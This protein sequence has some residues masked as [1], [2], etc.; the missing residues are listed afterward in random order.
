MDGQISLDNW[1]E[2][3]NRNPLENPTCIVKDGKSIDVTWRELFDSDK[4]DSLS[5]VTYVSS[6]AFLE[7]AVG[8]FKKVEIILGIEK[9]DFR[10]AFADSLK[11][12]I[13]SEGE[14]FFDSMPDESK[15]RLVNG[16]LQ[17]KYSNP[18]CIIHS[19]FYL[20]SNS[21]TSDTRLIVGS[22]NLTNTAFDNS[23]KQYEDV[24]VY[25]NDALF[26]VY[27]ERFNH[28]LKHT[29]DY[30]P[31]EVREKYKEGK[32]I[33]VVNMTS[34]ELTENLID[35]LKKNDVVLACNEEI[36][37]SLQEV[38]IDDAK[39]NEKYKS[40]LEIINTVSKKP[41]GDKSGK[42][43]MKTDSE[44]EK[45]K[46]NITDIL[47]RRT[48]SE[49]GMERYALTFN[50]AD[51]RQYRIFQ[52]N[53][54]DSKRDPEVYDREASKEEIKAGIENML[55]FLDAYRKF[56]IDQTEDDGR[57]SRLFEIILYAF[58]SAYIFRIRQS[59]S[60][61][62]EDVPVIL[63]I[64]GKSFSGKSNLL[65]Y[66]DRILSG[67]QLENSKHYI[68]YKDV[69]KGRILEDLFTT[70]NTYPL[71][72]D[73]M[74]PKFFTSTSSN[75]GEELIKYLANELDGKHPVM[76]CTTNADSFSIPSQVNRRIYYLKVDSTFDERKRSEAGEYYDE[77]MY[78]AKNFLFRDFCFRMREKIQTNEELLSLKKFD[79]LYAV[80]QIFGEYFK[81]AEIE[82]PSYFPTKLYRDYGERGIKMWR[83]LYSQE[84]DKF[85]YEKN[86]KDEPTFVI[87]LKELVQGNRDIQLY[88][89]HIRSDILDDSVGMFVVL[90]ANPFLEWIGIKKKRWLLFNKR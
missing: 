75:K 81:I 32:V 71:L 3:Q 76:I 85:H 55:R 36:L 6:A 22:A 14:Q 65:A 51:K 8:D 56:V 7:K 33:A 83:T 12:R 57:L 86:G 42:L 79:Y 11:S 18:D 21:T 29:E 50:D 45:V 66:I 88:I 47:F 52:T 84:K 58:A 25:D 30:V 73:E 23:I 5:C 80:R 77:V 38:Q 64:G 46:G 62:K 78:E 20:L 28:I 31:R 67:R 9:E 41:K 37:E 53:S 63:V 1:I 60:N 13:Y 43:I 19:K 61:K 54:K 4:Y 48:K 39:E 27:K 82:V 40:T 59:Y 87:N 10:R 16:D 70:D 89:N 49:A 90:K 44:L 17:V 15:Q 24:I 72:I 35:T 74:S 34:E 69:E 26:D 68:A 2:E